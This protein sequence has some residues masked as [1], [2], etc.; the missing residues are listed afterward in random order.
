MRFLF[1]QHQMKYTALDNRSRFHIVVV[2]MSV[3]L[4]DKT[5]REI[6]LLSK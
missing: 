2:E 4:V 1:L 5:L 3:Q 6:I